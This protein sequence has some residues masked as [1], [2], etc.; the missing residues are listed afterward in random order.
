MEL[1]DPAEALEWGRPDQGEGGYVVVE[2]G[3]E[4]MEAEVAGFQL[5]NWRSLKFCSTFIVKRQHSV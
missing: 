2:M 5:D 3:D 4:Q 1:K